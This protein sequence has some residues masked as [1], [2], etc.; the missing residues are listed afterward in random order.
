MDAYEEI[1]GYTGNVLIVH[2]DVDNLVNISG[3]EKALSMY[4]DSDAFAKLVIIS[5][6]GRIFFNAKHRE[7]AIYDILGFLKS[8]E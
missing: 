4:E 7:Q 1:K 2:G 3:S 8:D 5:G 6:A